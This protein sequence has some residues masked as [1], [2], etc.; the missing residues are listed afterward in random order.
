MGREEIRRA[1]W[2]NEQRRVTYSSLQRMAELERACRA[3]QAARNRRIGGRT[4]AARVRDAVGHIR[5][6]GKKK[7]GTPADLRKESTHEFDGDYTASDHQS[8]L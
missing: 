5:Q 4:R 7:A 3:V 8:Q 6:S 1:S 2:F